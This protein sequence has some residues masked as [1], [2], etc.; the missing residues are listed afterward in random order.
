M[1]AS[2][3]PPA[4]AAGNA[5]LQQ[6]IS[7]G[8]SRV[9]SLSGTVA[10]DSQR[11]AQLT[12]EVTA[13]ADRLAGLQQDLT[14][15]L[16]QLYRL[17]A[18][19]DAAQT[20]L[21][22]LEATE[23]TDE[24]VL[25]AQM[26]GTYEGGQPNLI[27][28][29]LESHGFNDL[30]ERLNFVQRVG[31]QDARIAASVKAA[32]RA[33]ATEAVR[34]GALSA[35]QQRVAQQ[36]LTE[37][38]SV[39]ATKVSLVSDQLAAARIRSR[40]AGQLAGARAQVA[41]LSA[42]LAQL[43]AAQ[44]AAAARAAQRAAAQRAA[45]SQPT[46]PGPAP[47]SSGSG[48]S[49]APSPPA[50]SAPSS[51]GFVFPMPRADASPPSSWSLDDGV[52]IS[53]PGGTP[54]LAVCSGTIVLHGIGGFGPSAPVLHCD[55]PLDGY[56]YVYYGHAGPGNWTPIGAHVGQG[57]VISQVGYGIVGISSGPHLELGFADSSG[58]PVGPSSAPAMMSLLQSSY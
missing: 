19:L 56:D 34:L 47:A 28:V 15:K 10:S 49:S 33:V 1:S 45:Q 54:E 22:R 14:A 39:G 17:R 57:Q 6:Q 12:R 35:H 31:N 58:A 23:A 38:N 52:D 41:S 27:E 42:Q 40:H 20:R 32:R 55:S 3:V 53:A 16:A 26:V 46:S 7:R 24:R 43:Q 5:Q 13:S 2:G 25:A 8:R 29:V 37:R 48:R 4:R 21:H 36:I 30:L 11:V 9:S 50:A 44:R 51:S 18:E